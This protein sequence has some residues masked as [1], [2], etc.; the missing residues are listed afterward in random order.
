MWPL[1]LSSGI[2]HSSA[3]GGELG[4]PA[5]EQIP[6]QL[7]SFTLMYPGRVRVC[8]CVHNKPVISNVLTLI[9]TLYLHTFPG[10]ICKEPRRR[11]HAGHVQDG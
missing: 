4:A 8:V 10:L 11:G 3:L 5:G 9:I 2:C 6:E 1:I 7:E